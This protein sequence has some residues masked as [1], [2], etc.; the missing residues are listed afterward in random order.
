MDVHEHSE[1]AIS[2][3]KVRVAS[4]SAY[5]EEGYELRFPDTESALAECRRIVDDFLLSAARPGLTSEELF[6]QYS[7]FGEDPYLVDGRA[8]FSAWDYARERCQQLA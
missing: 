3:V 5:G 2:P 8:T 7:L 4:N 1:G 6:K